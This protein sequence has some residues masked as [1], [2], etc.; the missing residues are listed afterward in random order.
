M[1]HD[2]IDR[3]LSEEDDIVPSSGFVPAVMEAVLYEAA[4]PP[5]IPFPWKC[6]FPGFAALALTLV[7]SYIAAMRVPEADSSALVTIL[8]GASSIGAD[9]ISVALL[10]SFVSVTV[11]MR[12]VRG[13]G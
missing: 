6:A 1:E 10:L 8:D 9:W 2:E 13:R 12:V 3:I 11:S 7:L 4:T 5:P